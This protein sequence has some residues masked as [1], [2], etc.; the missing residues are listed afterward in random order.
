MGVVY[1]A[2]DEQLGQHVALKTL[3]SVSAEQVYRLKQ[4]FRARTPV[5]HYNLVEL[6]ELV[7]TEDECFFTME[8]VDGVDLVQYVRQRLPDEEP[9]ALDGLGR[10]QSAFRQLASAVRALHSAGT[11]HRDLKPSNVLVTGEGRVVVL[12]FGLA[13]ALDT[14]R[15][16]SVSGGMVGTFAYMAPEQAWG[17]PPTAAMDW[18]SFGVVLYSAL[19]G[20]L[21][22]EGPVARVLRDKQ[23]R[24]QPRPRARVPST[25]ARLDELTFSLLDPDA[26]QRPRAAAILRG[27]EPDVPSG[28]VA[29]G[30]ASPEPDAALGD[31]DGP[32]APF[33]G[34]DREMAALRGYLAGMR[35]D[36]ATVV[37]VRGASGM[38]KTELLRRF[39]GELSAGDGLVL[40]G[41]CHPQESVPYKAVDHVVDGLSRHLLRLPPES[42]AG[43]VPRHAAALLH[44][45]PVLSRV[46]AFERHNDEQRLR[47]TDPHERRRRGFRALRELLARLADRQRT[48]V[49]IDDVQWGDEDSAQ[50]LAEVLRAPDPPAVMLVLSYRSE[51]QRHSPFL[52]ELLRTADPR[53][54][55]EVGPLARPYAL[56]LATQWLGEGVRGSWVGTIARESGGS[57]FFVGELARY[58]S[59]STHTP[60]SVSIEGAIGWRYDRLAAPA[61]QLL[62]VVAVAGG[63][64]E[65]PIVV[66]IAGVGD[67]ARSLVN[68]LSEQC[69]VRTSIAADREVVE[70]YHD[71][72]RETVVSSL[73][74]ERR[75]A[76]HQCVAVALRGSEDPDPQVLVEH[77]LRAGDETEAAV[78]AER[79]AERSAEAL[80]FG[81]AAE[82]YRLALRLR[83]NTDADWR[84]RV[85]LAETLANAGR[86]GE[87]GPEFE[88]AAS[89]AVRD[90]DVDRSEV[91][92]LRRFAA[93]QLLRVGKVAD[94]VAAL[95]RV[96]QEAGVAYP[97]SPATALVS[98]LARRVQLRLRGL[99]FHERSPSDVRKKTLQ[100]IDV[101]WTATLGLNMIDIVRSASFQSRHTLMALAAGEPSRVARALTT[102]VVYLANEGGA[103]NRKRSEAILDQ[104]EALT[105]RT[106]DP[107]ARA[108]LHLCAGAAGYFTGQWRMAIERLS[109]GEALFGQIQGAHWEV[110]NCRIYRLWS[111]ATLG[112][113]ETLGAEQ[114]G[115]VAAAQ[116]SGDV[117]A[118]MGLASGLPNLAW[119]VRGRHVDARVRANA[120][121]AAFPGAG[122]QSPHYFDL[123]GQT[124]I[125]LYRGDGWG[126]FGR[127]TD[128]WPQLKRMQFLRLQF[129]R[130]EL[131]ALRARCALAAAVDERPP[132]GRFEAWTTERLLTLAEDATTRLAVE[133][134]RF[135]PPLAAALTIALEAAR[136]RPPTET[137]RALRAALERLES[138][139]LGLY[140][141]SARWHTAVLAGES[142]SWSG[143][144]EPALLARVLLPGISR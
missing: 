102:E 83:A 22:F 100:R 23:S 43:L 93:E 16:D 71:R 135:A 88:R 138:A 66:D 125:D 36:E 142:A 50:L 11:L 78:F 121:I 144:A 136:G 70:P 114:P 82:L 124:Q 117:M 79:A 94:G 80:A 111:L 106:G 53:H 109:A 122:F 56:E 97:R 77:Y 54:V 30:A 60:Q 24:P 18:Y 28:A 27:L 9:L 35:A 32:G 58:V 33:L 41:R 108:F 14:A 74:A 44:L 47:T 112:E 85:A 101:C 120:A 6:Y 1:R 128:R 131:W 67:G 76:L 59:E 12:D 107:K 84:M 4:E 45:F 21:P 40:R 15:A 141:A 81:R 92:D 134:A 52:A 140:A 69:L 5:N 25:P 96:C 7:A 127:V 31:I 86:G 63:A 48:L 55:L 10:L 51:D 17:Q 65:V 99:K 105:E 26:E 126:A 8:L 118:E 115:L 91:L 73:T 119:L 129:F 130:V 37:H 13:A 89:A 39:L 116:S 62:E 49:W 133:D 42:V 95:R 2:W 46:A 143:V 137:A 29:K 38:G 90:S 98:V 19:T 87:A 113:L 3:N 123:L 103:A 20:R 68:R 110:A 64:L 139:E 104:V 132:P 75:R 57:P 61:R 72:I 34:R